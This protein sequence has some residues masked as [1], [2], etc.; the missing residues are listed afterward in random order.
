MALDLRA[1]WNEMIA[2]AAKTLGVKWNDAR[3]YAEPEMKKIA[4]TI[5]SIE[6][7]LLAGDI[8][9][10][11]ATLL[12]DMQKN[13]SRSVLLA[14][15]VIGLVTAEKVINDALALVRDTVNSAVGFVLIA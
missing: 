1:L 5:A 13:A 14:V 4:T 8:N 7:S 6:A 15:E 11:Q 3:A 9:Q 12:L 2:A 10:Q